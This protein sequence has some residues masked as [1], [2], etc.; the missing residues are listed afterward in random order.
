MRE[1]LLT[2]QERIFLHHYRNKTLHRF[3]EIVTYCAV[4]DKLDHKGESTLDDN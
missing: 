2:G 4:L 3:R 1:E